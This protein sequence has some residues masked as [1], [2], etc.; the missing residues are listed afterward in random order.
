[1][2]PGQ[3]EKPVAAS[4]VSPSLKASVDRSIPSIW[5]YSTLIVRSGSP[6]PFAGQLH[7]AQGSAQA[8]LVIICLQVAAYPAWP[9]APA[10]FSSTVQLHGPRC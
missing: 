5:L 1:M 10:R 4:L 3:T 8:Q 9:K 7:S 6:G 2:L